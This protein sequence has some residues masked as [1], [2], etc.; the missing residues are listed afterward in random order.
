M[1]SADPK[2][3]CYKGSID[4]KSDNKVEEVLK[5]E[6]CD[7]GVSQCLK[8]SSGSMTGKTSAKITK[9]QCTERIFNEIANP[10]KKTFA[11]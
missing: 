5:K 11:V 8:T 9:S 1:Q 6:M 2:I 3:K 10:L 7:I 4:A